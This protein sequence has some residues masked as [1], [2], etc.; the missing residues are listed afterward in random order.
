MRR[1]GAA[2]DGIRR[3]PGSRSALFL[4]PAALLARAGVPGRFAPGHWD[5]ATNAD[6]LVLTFRES[7]SGG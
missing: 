4:D 5:V 2:A 6:G 3:D 1:P 7:A